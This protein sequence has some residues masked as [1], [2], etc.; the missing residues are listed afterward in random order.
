MVTFTS[1]I[2][3]LS[4]PNCGFGETAV[5]DTGLIIF[6]T[7]AGSPVPVKRT[8]VDE[9]IKQ[10]QI[11]THCD[12]NVDDIVEFFNNSRGLLVEVNAGDSPL[13]TFDCII[14][15]DPLQVVELRTDLWSIE[16]KAR[17]E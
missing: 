3:S 13:G 6:K 4:L 9:T 2:G 1:S 16:I 5:I 12:D 8:S 14:L 7:P 11:V 15:Q 10:F 17:V